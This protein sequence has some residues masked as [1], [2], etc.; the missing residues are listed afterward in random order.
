MGHWLARHVLARFETVEQAEAC[1][2]NLA[3]FFPIYLDRLHREWS[4]LTEDELA[5]MLRRDYAFVLGET[6]YWGK[7]GAMFEYPPLVSQLGEE[8]IIYFDGCHRGDDFV[9]LFGPTLKLAGATSLTGGAGTHVSVFYEFAAPS[10]KSSTACAGP[11]ALPRNP[12]PEHTL[13]ARH[14][15]ARALR[16]LENCFADGVTLTVVSYQECFGRGR[17]EFEELETFKYHYW[18]NGVFG[19][20]SIPFDGDLALLQSFFSKD[21]FRR[22]R[23]RLG[24]AF[25][26]IQALKSLAQCSACGG[27]RVAAWPTDEESFAEAIC[28]G[29][30]VRSLLP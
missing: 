24:A 20:L 30:E 3:R 27:E 6:P 18:S 17:G 15:S 29:C 16:R 19:A 22:Y 12:K 21:G 13:R 5:S 10:S 2:R 8:L 25:E 7:D 11:A 23:V 1:R 28:T 14:E 9:A 26:E 4:G